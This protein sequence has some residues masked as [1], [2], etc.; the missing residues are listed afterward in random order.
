VTERFTWP[1]GAA[2]PAA[3]AAGAP[4]SASATSGPEAA[5]LDTQTCA[6][7][8][9]TLLAAST[10]EFDHASAAIRPDHAPLLDGV[11]RIAGL[12]P[13][14]LRIE[15]HTDNAG[16]AAFNADLSRKRANAVRSALIQRGMDPTR[17]YAAGHGADRPVADNDSQAGRARNRR[18]EIH[19]VPPPT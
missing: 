10:I 13:G 1:G 18:I 8:M 9:S 17:I 5:P 11:V 19:L 2:Q 16:G 3:L 15:G 4:L 14:A 12:C 6:A 7:F